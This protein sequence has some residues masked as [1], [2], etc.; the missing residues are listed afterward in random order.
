MDQLSPT[1]MDRRSHPRI[2]LS[3]SLRYA[4][5]Q[6]EATP[7]ALGRGTTVDV[8]ASGAQLTLSQPVKVPS[9]VQMGISVPDRTVPVILLARTIWCR[10]EEDGSF[11][12]GL[13]FMGHIDP[14]FLELLES[15]SAVS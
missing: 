1:P 4:T 9:Y 8:S 11:R 2:N 5:C 13:Q 6:D 14:A 12:T 15:K 10:K 7:M 3:A